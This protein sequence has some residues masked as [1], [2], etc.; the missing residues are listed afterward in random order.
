MFHLFSSG[1]QNITNVLDLTLKKLKDKDPAMM[2]EI[3]DRAG[4]V[5]PAILENYRKQIISQIEQA[6]EHVVTDPRA[7][8]EQYASRDPFVGLV[9]TNMGYLAHSLNPPASPTWQATGSSMGTLT[10]GGRCAQ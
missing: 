6:K 5:D 1:H 7:T 8:I 3:S 2:K 9:Q 10:P 4:T